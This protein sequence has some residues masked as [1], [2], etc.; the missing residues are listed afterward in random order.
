MGKN[1]IDH[2]THSGT[3]ERN[4]YKYVEHKYENILQFC[5]LSTFTIKSTTI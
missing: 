3:E 4:K 2:L 1:E 5:N